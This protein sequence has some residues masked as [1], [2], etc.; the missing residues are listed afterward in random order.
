MGVLLNRVRFSISTT[1]QRIHIQNI[2][3]RSPVK[4]SEKFSVSLRPITKSFVIGLI[5]LHIIHNVINGTFYP[6]IIRRREIYNFTASYFDIQTVCVTSCV[7]AESGETGSQN[8]N[9]CG[10]AKLL[11][12]FLSKRRLSCLRLC[13]PRRR[14]IPTRKER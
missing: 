4:L 8:S 12:A 5:P 9:S 3:R 13:E 11:P 10:Q 6:K 1:T 7:V 14:H 2:W